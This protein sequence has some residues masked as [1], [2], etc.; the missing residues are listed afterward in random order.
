MK[1]TDAIISALF[2]KAEYVMSWGTHN[3]ILADNEVRI[4]VKA[5]KF[6]GIVEIRYICIR[7]LYRISLINEDGSINHIEEDLPIHMIVDKIDELIEFVENYED[8]V[9]ARYN[10]K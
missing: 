6:T 5:L 1:P 3:L 10:M 9:K 4:S 7:D 2:S 8:V